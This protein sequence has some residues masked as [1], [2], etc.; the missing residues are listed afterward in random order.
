MKVVIVDDEKEIVD[1]YGIFLKKNGITDY[2]KYT[3]PRSFLDDLDRLEPEIVFL[4]LHMPHYTGED[5]LEVVRSSHP[6]TSVVILTG[7]VD[8]EPAVRCMQKGAVDYLVKPIDKNRF[9]AAY[10]SAV[11]AYKMRTEIQALRTAM[12]SP[13]VQKSE[14][15][16][17]IVTVNRQMHELFSYVEAVSKSSFPV[18]ITGETGVGKELFARAVHESSGRKGLFVAVNVSGLDDNMFSDTIFGH[19]KG[20]FTGADRPRKGMIS[21]AEGGTLFL[22]EIGDMNENTQMKL[23][24]VL[25]EKIYMPL[26]SDKYRQADVRIVAATNA[27]L[28]EK[29]KTGAFR[30]DLLF[31]L[32]THALVIPPLRDRADDIPLLAD[33]FYKKALRDVGSQYHGELPAAAV[34]ALKRYPFP[35]NIRQLQAVT[36][37]M[38]AVFSSGR[39]KDNEVINF[40]KKHGIEAKLCPAGNGSS[41]SYIGCFP[42]LKEMERYLVEYAVNTAEGNVSTA[43]KMLGITRQ[44]LHKRLKPAK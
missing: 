8:I 7:S 33:I 31:R 17:G 12:S 10:N 3:D 36:A 2:S 23:L 13:R 25:Q 5:L 42:T 35:G 20:A 27:D 1:A 6:Q 30:Q 11:N 9:E 32:S 26:G 15:F 21:E 41:F 44:A 40:L 28:S 22:D 14:D 38:A 18:L 24:R 43:A 39:P 19:I 34:E 37:D 16:H 29:V 4:D